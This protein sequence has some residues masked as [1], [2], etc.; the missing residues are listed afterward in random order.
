[1]LVNQRGQDLKFT[2]YR[3]PTH[4]RRYLDFDFNH[5]T[6]HKASGVS[7]LP[8]RAATIC[9]SETDKKK[10]KKTIFKDLT[11]NGYSSSFI[12]RIVRRKALAEQNQ[13]PDER[14]P[15]RVARKCL[16]YVKGTSEALAR[17][18]GKVGILVAHKPTFTVGR[19]MPRPNVRLPK[20][21][22]LSVVYTIP[23]AEC[24][25]TYTSETNF[26]ER[27]RQHKNDVRKFDSERSD[28]AEHY[29]TLDHRIDFANA[30]VVD[31]EPN[32]RRSLFLESYGKS[33]MRKEI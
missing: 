2:V 27:I 29:D 21:R 7:T 22:S 31:T 28:I 6:S 11:K 17:V 9:S 3:K 16:P 4:T 32:F 14:Q 15:H 30:H 18:P 25:A 33:S 1:M 8:R 24:P 19:L 20:E 23:C 13:M 10:E 5:S 12:E 26:P